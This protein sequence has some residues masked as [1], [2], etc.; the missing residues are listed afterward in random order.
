MTSISQEIKTTR[1]K[2]EED[3]INIKYHFHSKVTNLS[4]FQGAQ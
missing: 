2:L 3:K 1:D 4:M